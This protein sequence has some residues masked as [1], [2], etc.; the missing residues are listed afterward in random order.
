MTKPAEIADMVKTTEKTFG[1]LDVLVNNAGIQHVAAVEDFPP[2]KWDQ[3]IAINLSAAFH[4]CHAAVAGHEGGRKWGRHQYG[5]GAFAGRL[6]VQ[7]RL[8]RG[9]ARP[10]GPDQDRR[11][12]NRDLRHHLQLHQPRLRVDAAGREADPRPDEDAQ[13]DRGA[14]QARR[15]AGR[16]ADQAIRHRRSGR[17]AGGYLCSDAAAPITGANISIDGGWTAE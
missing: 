17:G 5:V 6:A 1:A 16:A 3:I 11:A 13:H 14:G 9:Q 7:G 8:H 10:R 12:R 2:E 15:A 4:T